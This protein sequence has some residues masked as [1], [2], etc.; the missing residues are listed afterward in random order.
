[1]FFMMVI[2]LH[3]VNPVH[4]RYHLVCHV[5]VLAL[6]YTGS[7]VESSCGRAGYHESSPYWAE[8]RGPSKTLHRQVKTSD[9]ISIPLDGHHGPSLFAVPG[10]QMLG[11]CCLHFRILSR[12]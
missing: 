8:K 4:L 1:M 11:L 12:S 5:E 6:R 2:I 10:S 9:G 7:M 3:P